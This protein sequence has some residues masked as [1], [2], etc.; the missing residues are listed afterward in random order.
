[1]ST[2]EADSSTSPS[3]TIHSCL[4][5][6]DAT[7]SDLVLT[8]LDLVELHIKLDLQV[9]ESLNN[10]GNDALA[11]L[12]CVFALLDLQFSRVHP[13]SLRHDGSFTGLLVAI[14]TKRASEH[15]NQDGVNS[16][17]L[18]ELG[19]AILDCLKFHNSPPGTDPM[20][21]AEVHHLVVTDHITM[22]SHWARLACGAAYA[23]PLYDGGRFNFSVGPS[24][25]AKGPRTIR[26]GDK[27][28]MRMIAKDTQVATLKNTGSWL[29]NTIN[30]AVRASYP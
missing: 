14:D 29:V 20:A 16:V 3:V 6:V 24:S 27:S 26:V 9:P 22:K 11:T 4:C 25:G 10:A 18:T 7:P 19:V 12:R 1:M 15:Y 8:R 13:E 21:C 2:R 5:T 30:D 23:V 28:T 17:R